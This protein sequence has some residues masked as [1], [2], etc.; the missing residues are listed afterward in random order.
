MKS[1]S[2]RKDS[3]SLKIAY[4]AFL[5]DIIDINDRDITNKEKDFLG[6]A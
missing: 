3:N 5:I 1:S 4:R 6:I 2:L